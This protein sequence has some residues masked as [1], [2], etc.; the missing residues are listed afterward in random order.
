MRNIR[1]E[2]KRIWEGYRYVDL[3]QANA[4][5]FSVRNST[6]SLMNM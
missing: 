4:T 6:N 3:T 5:G 2:K 1:K